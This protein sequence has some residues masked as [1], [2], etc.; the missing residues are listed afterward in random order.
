[1]S[2]NTQKTRS[3]IRRGHRISWYIAVVFS[4]ITVIVCLVSLVWTPY[5]PSAMDLPM[6]FALPSWSHPFGCDQFGRDILSR[7]MVAAQPAC[8][9][10]FGAVSLGALAGSA[11][12]V[13]ATMGSRVMRAVLMRIIDGI[14]AFP[15][16]MLALMLVLVMG[17]GL[18]S[19]LIA[20]SVFVLPTFARISYQLS[21]DVNQSLAVRAAQSYGCSPVRIALCHVVPHIASALL[22]QLSA[23]IGTAMLLEAALSFLGLG[24]QPPLASWGTMLSES[25]TYVI[26]HPHIAVAPGC[27]LLGSVLGFNMLGDV[28]SDVLTQRGNHA[29]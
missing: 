17:R 26:L 5:D 2:T 27:A 3:R 1:M 21:L 16:I 20:V 9:V 13:I 7:T 25:F 12:G 11:I 29:A 14:M 19:A 8:A 15:G 18:L 28:I 4:A 24:I 23:A 6:R 10:G 22:V